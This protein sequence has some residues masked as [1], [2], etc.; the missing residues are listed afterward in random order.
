MPMP[1]PW[2]PAPPHQPDLNGAVEAPLL[3]WP[4]GF[5]QASIFANFQAVAARQPQALAVTDGLES[6]SFAA[7]RAEALRLAGLLAER[8]PGQG[9]VALLLP[10]APLALA[11]VLACS[12]AGRPC[13]LLNAHNPA[14][15][16]LA[17]LRQAAPEVV[18]ALAE[19]RLDAPDLAW[20][21]ATLPATPLATPAA[22]L[23]LH[24]PALVV[25]T[26][27]S[28]GMPK[29]MVLSEC[30]ELRRAWRN[31]RLLRLHP[32]DRMLVLNLLCTIAGL[33][34]SIAALLSGAGVLLADP[35]RLGGRRLLAL[36][37]QQGATA[38]LG[39]P[40]VLRML[41]ALD[42]GGSATARLRAVRTTG[43]GLLAQELA[44][45]R[46]R[47]PPGC[48]ITISYGQTEMAIAD[49]WVPADFAATEA[50]LPAGYLLDQL[51]YALLDASGTAV[52]AGE[53]GALV[54][55]SDQVALGEWRA[56][57]C[58]PGGIAPDPENPALRVLHTGDLARLRPDGLLQ[59]LGRSDR[60]AKV[61]GVRVEPAEVEAVLRAVPGVAAAVV[62]ARPG[63]GGD[64][65][66]GFVVPAPGTAAEGLPALLR[67]R[68][69]QAL[70][71]PMHPATLHCLPGLPRLPGG[72]VDEAA[73]LA[74]VGHN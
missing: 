11:A 21:D 7:L 73:L 10:S 28:T 20:L 14:E 13:L 55:R 36:A 65:L 62:L 61:R 60:Q 26:S 66:R 6:L 3:P 49:W 42:S 27:G 53:A 16:S 29:G 8:A 56:G 58:L 17:T 64:T 19:T 39:I 38:V 48:R 72:K 32:A 43:T 1:I 5:A 2:Q 4:E 35:A 71:P 15:R 57:R 12:A 30:I 44:E 46:Q 41:L 25:Y 33:G 74:L 50:A 31:G 40:A 54:V 18:L 23:P 24:A 34:A 63:P 52:P 9:A 22:R 51:D 47:L 37:R 67:A 68:L 59:V 45:W 70:P 69:A